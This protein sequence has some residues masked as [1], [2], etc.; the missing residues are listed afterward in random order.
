MKTEILVIGRHPEIM[1]T[2]LRLINKQEQWHGQGTLKDDEAVRLFDLQAFDIVLLSSGIEE[3][4]ER[5]LCAY[6]RKK[7]ADVIIIQHYG[8]GSGLLANEIR[9]AL[10]ERKLKS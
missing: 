4:I 6:F 10:D 9:Q 2:L 5:K 8:G 7:K 3:E 1:E